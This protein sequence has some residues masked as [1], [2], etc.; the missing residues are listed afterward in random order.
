MTKEERLQF[1]QAWLEAENIVTVIE[2][3]FVPE[4]HFKRPEDCG[5]QEIVLLLQFLRL[6]VKML[7][8]D[9]ESTEREN[10][11]LV[12]LVEHK[13]VGKNQHD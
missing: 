2:P 1:T 4:E 3:Q 6:Q 7:L 11:V 8:H 12:N 10:Q 9:K 13:Q 5:P